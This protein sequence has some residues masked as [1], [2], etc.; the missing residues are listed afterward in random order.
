[1]NKSLLPDDIS[2]YMHR[3][4]VKEAA[5]L[6]ALREETAKMEEAGMQ[7]SADQGHFL[8]FLIN[9]IGA[10]R[11]L[12]VGV[13]TGY[14]SLATALALPEHG[15]HV[16]CDVSEVYTAVARRHWEAAGV[17]HKIELR[18][19]PA[20]ETLDAL[21]AEGAVFDFCFIDADKPNYCN[22]YERAVQLL[23]PNGVIAVDN[24]LWHGQIVDTEDMSEGTVAIRQLNAMVGSD[25]RVE[26]TLVP[27]G[28]GMTLARKR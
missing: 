12:E 2:L 3:T 11:T 16:A 22:Y 25:P 19:G 27:L 13:F 8:S 21:L 15:R 17:S 5:V 4:F 6:N 20:V 18:L 10:E 1:M 14:S 7:I 26:A 28:D 23:R 24:T 9:L